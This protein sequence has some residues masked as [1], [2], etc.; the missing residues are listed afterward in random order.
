MIES[1]SVWQAIEDESPPR[2][3]QS[4][5]L[6]RLGSGPLARAALLGITAGM[7]L[8]VLCDW[9]YDFS[10]LAFPF[11]FYLRGAAGRFALYLYIQGR[12]WARTGSGLAAGC[13][14]ILP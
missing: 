9:L 1:V 10:I 14:A 3:R 5:A 7:P 12:G 2:V 6:G 13:S 8:L 4:A 11:A